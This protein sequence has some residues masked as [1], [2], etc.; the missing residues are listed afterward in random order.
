MVELSVG[1]FTVGGMRMRT[2]RS[3]SQ[4]PVHMHIIKERAQMQGP[5]TKQQA[6]DAWVDKIA[7]SE[8]KVLFS[9]YNVFRNRY[10]DHSPILKLKHTAIFTNDCAS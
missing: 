7:G 2:G 6:I 5:P 1:S 8:P 4:N 9:S 3:N 10:L